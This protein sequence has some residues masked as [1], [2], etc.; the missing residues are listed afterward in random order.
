MYTD[1]KSKL[2]AQT[3]KLKTNNTEAGTEL[4]EH[5]DKG[6]T[7]LWSR[8]L[9]RRNYVVVSVLCI[10]VT[11]SVGRG[12]RRD[13]WRVNGRCNSPIRG[14]NRDL[15]RH[16]ERR[17]KEVFEDGAAMTGQERKKRRAFD[18]RTF[19]EKRLNQARTGL[20]IQNLCETEHAGDYE[21]VGIFILESPKDLGRLYEMVPVRIVL[22]TWLAGTLVYQHQF[23]ISFPKRFMFIACE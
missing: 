13:D 12:R 1:A 2:V 9:G 4:N 21:R 15:V 8:R 6:N 18:W 10:V 5:K 3:R 20:F 22:G 14:S 11:G 19:N 17:T 16:G 7:N 23:N